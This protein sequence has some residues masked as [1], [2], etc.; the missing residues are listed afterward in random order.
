M[1]AP[2]TGDIREIY[3]RLLRWAAAN[4]HTRRPA[5]TPNELQRELLGAMPMASAAVELI[6]QNYEC[7]RYGDV[8]IEDAAIAASRAASEHLDDLQPD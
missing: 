1:V 5:T 8:A 3:R 4:G 6:T 2:G 7:A